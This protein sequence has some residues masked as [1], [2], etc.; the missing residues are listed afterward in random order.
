MPMPSLPETDSPPLSLSELLESSVVIVL[1]QVLF[2]AI[3]WAFFM[4]TLFRDYDV[5]NKLVRLL[6]SATFSGACTLFELVIFEILNITNARARWIHWKFTLYA[7]LVDVVVV[8]PFYQFYLVFAERKKWAPY[9]W[10]L[11][12]IG[13]LIYALLFW[14]VGDQFPLSRPRTQFSLTSLEPFMGRVGV[15]GVTMMAILSGFGAVNS[16]YTT[17]FIFL[18]N[19]SEGDVQEAQRRLMQN[20]QRILTKKKKLALDMYKRR[21]EGPKGSYGISGLLRRAYHNVSSISSG[22]E[23]L[24]TQMSS[25][26]ALE[27]VCQQMF[28]ELD[29]M[30]AERDKLAQAQTAQGKL[31][32]VLGYGFSIYC[33]WKVLTASINVLFNRRGTVDPVTHGL[34]LGVHYLG[35]S[36]DIEFWSQQL[37]FV[38]VGIMVVVSIRGLLIQ[39]TKWFRTFSSSVSPN[40]ITIFLAHIM[41]IY[42]LST[43]LMLRMNL[44]PQYRTIISN[45]LGQIEFDFY[46]HWFDVIF[47]VSAVVS[48]L[49]IYLITQLQKRR[50]SDYGLNTRSMGGGG[51]GLL[52]KDPMLD[53][54]SLDQS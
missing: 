33:F 11:A 49:F 38:L 8:L 35:I 53:E 48:M 43:V 2:F 32:N 24:D 20:Y 40:N 52:D 22:R 15:I 1:S 16:P 26:E 41:G 44:P 13:W 4:G 18:R 27:S 46:N 45:V 28:L 19:V 17:L 9:R 21:E 47:I 14:K 25:I 31:L 36:I 54:Y 7:M 30:N 51:G 12:F 34:N 3:G 10:I 37:S 50:E 29:E 5:R 42:F 39:F 6:F 23:S